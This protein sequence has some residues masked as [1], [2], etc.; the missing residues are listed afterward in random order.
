MSSLVSVQVGDEK[1]WQA[2]T[3]RRTQ[4]KAPDS[5]LEKETSL[6]RL[7]RAETLEDDD[8]LQELELSINK[9]SRG[10]Y[11]V[12]LNHWFRGYWDAVIIIALLFTAIVTPFEVAFLE[13]AISA[14]FIVNRFVDVT[15]LADMVLILMT[16]VLDEEKGVWIITNWGIFKQYAR[17]WLWI[18]LLSVIPFDAVSIAIELQGGGSGNLQG[19]RL[20]RLLRLIKL[21][22]V[23]RASRIIK[24]RE[25]DLELK[26]STLTLFKFL[27]IILVLTHWISCLMAL[28]PQLDGQTYDN[29]TPQEIANGSKPF[30][31]IVVYFEGPLGFSYGEYNIWSVYLAGC[32]FAAMTLTTIGY[33]DVTPKTDAERGVVCMIMLLGATFYAYAVGNICSIVQNMDKLRSEFRGEC[34]E[35]ANF[36]DSERFPAD[37]KKR[38]KKYIHFTWN[39]K[40]ATR[41]RELLDRLSV[42]LQ[43]EI[44]FELARTW[45]ARIP[46]ISPAVAPPSSGEYEDLI[47]EV[48]TKLKP[49]AFPAGETLRSKGDVVDKLFLIE[50]G[51]ACMHSFPVK[52]ALG[53]EGA[54]SSAIFDPDDNLVVLP[55]FG[56]EMIVDN[57]ASPCYVTAVT[58]VDVL[59]LTKEDLEEILERFPVAKS[60]LRYLSH[61]KHWEQFKKNAVEGTVAFDPEQ[62]QGEVVSEII[63]LN[64][65]LKS[66]GERLLKL[67]EALAIK[68]ELL[69]VAKEG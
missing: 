36:L 42:A 48:S 22:R 17:F 14:L 59:V 64:H 41:Q 3:E 65:D 63:E 50:R 66:L 60:N 18:D 49:D 7:I 44:A 46:F 2:V 11:L 51:R 40:Q 47:Q 68:Q 9:Q 10:Q 61:R 15:F 28:I 26:Y 19:I 39:K 4:S 58:D 1:P 31:W 21:I 53:D 33:G 54:S 20:L 69:K 8:D 30:N 23:V 62:G 29:F 27:V 5:T 13:P 45:V 67:E 35:F 56:E 57:Y 6:Q 24:R 34:D 32:Y 55:S 37:M 52:S 12:P 25:A 38:L 43:K 16:P